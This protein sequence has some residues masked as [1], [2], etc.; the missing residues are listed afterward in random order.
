LNSDTQYDIKNKT[1][2][3]TGVFNLIGVSVENWN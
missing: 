1:D 3:L 2:L